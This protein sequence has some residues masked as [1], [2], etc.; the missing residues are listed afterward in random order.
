MRFIE[1]LCEGSS[2]VPAV[3]EILCRHFGLRPGEHFRVHPHA[4]KGKL[5]RNPM[6]RPDSRRRGLLD[7]LPA[8]LRGYGKSENEGYAILVVVLVD[9]D[10]DDC[11]ALKRSLLKLYE[12]LPRKPAQV[13]FRIAVEETESWF[14]ADPKAVRAAFHGVD[15]AALHRLTPD[16]ICGAWESLARTLGMDPAEC[17]GADKVRWAEAIAPHLD[18][19]APKSPSLRAFV[20]GL[21]GRLRQG[22]LSQ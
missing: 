11:H 12:D 19:T 13:L 1:V 8:K 21:E 16:G 18:L 22:E 2:D 5:P 15:V 6:A 7:Q 20:D 17:S 3:R 10:D 4:G 14:L 9:A